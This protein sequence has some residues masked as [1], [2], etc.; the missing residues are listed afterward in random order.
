MNIRLRL[1]NCAKVDILLNVQLLTAVHQ[2]KAGET[3]L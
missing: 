3:M 1:S 2:V